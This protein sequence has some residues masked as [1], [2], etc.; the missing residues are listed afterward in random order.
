MCV[1][2]RHIYVVSISGLRISIISFK[3][4]FVC[5]F[6]TV[7]FAYIVRLHRSSGY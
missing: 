5:V 1:R 2:T 3:Y 6:Y 4:G 7:H